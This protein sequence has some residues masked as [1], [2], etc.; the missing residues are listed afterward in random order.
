MHLQA[1]SNTTPSTTLSNNP[2]PAKHR[3]FNTPTLGTIVWSYFPHQEATEEGE[4]EPTR[5][6]PRPALVVGVAE[7]DGNP[8][9][10]VVPGTTKKTEPEHIYPSEMI[11][12]KTDDDYT[13]TGLSHDTK[14]KFE[15]EIKLPYSDE[16]FAIPRRKPSNPVAPTSPRLGIL[17]YSYGSA[18]CNAAANATK[19]Q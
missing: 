4:E 11:I 1:T 19:H 13:Y 18:V 8:Y 6:K 7:D 2:Q 3:F 16:Y 17:P 9:V 14:F 10:I 12:R 5:P 15:R